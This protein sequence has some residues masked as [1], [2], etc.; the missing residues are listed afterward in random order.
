MRGN[1]LFDAWPYLT[2]ALL[3]VVIPVRY[4][5]TRRNITG[6]DAK[7]PQTKPAFRRSM[8]WRSSLAASLLF[9]LLVLAFPAAILS[10]NRSPVRLYVVEFLALGTGLLALASC[11]RLLW[12]HL[13]GSTAAITF[14]VC[15]TI[16]FALLSLVLLS[17]CLI[18]VLHRWGSSWAAL[19]LSPYV[20]SLL[21]GRPASVLVTQMPFLV[22]LHVFS[23]FA[24]VA[25]FPLTQLAARAVALAHSLASLIDHAFLGVARDTGLR[26]RQFDPAPWLWP[27]ED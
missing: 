7:I 1:F 20:I 22:R 27:E 16:F 2:S 3:L 13:Q 25:A 10:W 24:A 4:L 8:I 6:I 21:R 12:V 17:G 18:V 11:Y 14:D 19:T 5:R 23:A 15:D 9:H 26:L